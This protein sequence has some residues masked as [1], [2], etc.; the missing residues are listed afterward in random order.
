MIRQPEWQSHWFLF[1]GLVG[2]LSDPSGANLTV[3]STPGTP[4][5]LPF[6]DWEKKPERMWKSDITPLVRKSGEHWNDSIWIPIHRLCP[7]QPLLATISFLS[8]RHSQRIRLPEMAW[9]IPE[10][11]NEQLHFSYFCKL[12]HF[13]RSNEDIFQEILSVVKVQPSTFSTNGRLN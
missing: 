4:Q 5:K 1:I 9:L 3:V 8:W 2:W 13:D 7:V 6:V 11:Q 10:Q 12:S